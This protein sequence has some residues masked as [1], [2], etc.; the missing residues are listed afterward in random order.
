MAQGL[1]TGR[2]LLGSG[3]GAIV[4]AFLMGLAGMLAKVLLTGNGVAYFASVAAAIL[5]IP[6]SGPGIWLT[7]AVV[8][9]WAARRDSSLGRPTAFR[10]AGLLWG[11]GHGVVAL[12]LCAVQM[13]PALTT[14]GYGV[15]IVTGTVATA[16]MIYLPPAP[17]H[18][19]VLLGPIVSGWLAGAIF[20][21][22]NK[23][24]GR[25]ASPAATSPVRPAMKKAL[26]LSP[27]HCRTKPA[28]NAA[29]APPA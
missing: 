7:L 24:R 9:R 17:D 14:V 6:L 19:F 23:G 20:G 1:R 5:N 18:L 27:C 10:R 2:W 15:S 12:I 29:V 16:A 25:P 11:V 13:V 21:A 3:L 22:I 4:A 8:F 26:A 28:K